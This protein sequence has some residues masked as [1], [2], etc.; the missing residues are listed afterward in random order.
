MCFTIASLDK[1][2]EPIA[3]YH[4]SDLT[5]YDGKSIQPLYKLQKRG[6]PHKT[7]NDNYQKENENDN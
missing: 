6:R 2:N 5:L 1:P 4:V 7:S 3:T